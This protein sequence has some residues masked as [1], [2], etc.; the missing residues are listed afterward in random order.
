VCTQLAQTLADSRGPL[1]VSTAAGSLLT[2]AAVISTPGLSH[3]FG[4]T[5]VDPLGWGQA[6]F[7][8]AVASLLSLYAPA[9]L[10]RL[11][12]APDSS[13]LDDEDTDPQEQGVDLVDR[14]SQQP[15]TGVDEDVRTNEAGNT[16]H[17][18]R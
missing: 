13:V 17:V 5:P 11:I 7:A 14:R 3:I 10:E 12:P 4:C 2:L 1:V 18:P 15:G 16:G 9:L 8:T 6:F